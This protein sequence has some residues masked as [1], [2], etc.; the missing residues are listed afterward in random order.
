MYPAPFKKSFR[1]VFAGVSSF[2]G[3]VDGEVVRPQ[4]GDVVEADG[5]LYVYKGEG[6]QWCERNVYLRYV[7]LELATADEIQ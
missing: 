1:G 4:V 2:W 6:N 7:F 3:V 5:A